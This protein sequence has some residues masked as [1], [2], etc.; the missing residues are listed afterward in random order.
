M[1]S[2]LAMSAKTH[3]LTPPLPLHVALGKVHLSQVSEDFLHPQLSFL[4]TTL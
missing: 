3:P 4:R 1:R 2:Y